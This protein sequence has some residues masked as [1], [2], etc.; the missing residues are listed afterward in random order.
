MNV[1]LT[2]RILEPSNPK[3]Q[4]LVLFG[5]LLVGH[6]AVAIPEKA[7][8]FAV[9]L[10]PGYTRA[11]LFSTAIAFIVTQYIYQMCRIAHKKYPMFL[12][13]RKHL[14]F[15]I[16]LSVAVPLILAPA[17]AGGYFYF[18][19]PYKNIFKNT[20]YFFQI[21]PIVVLFVVLGNFIFELF[22]WVQDRY[23]HDSANDPI[24]IDARGRVIKSATAMVLVKD[25]DY[26]APPS[27]IEPDCELL[28]FNTIIVTPKGVRGAYGMR[29]SEY[30]AEKLI[31][32]E[33]RLPKEFFRISE[34]VFVNIPKVHSITADRLERTY[35]FFLDTDTNELKV[36]RRRA[37]DFRIIC[38]ELG[39][40][41][42]GEKVPYRD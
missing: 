30:L 32:I 7:S 23:A 39:I 25:S 5:S 17:L 8:F 13:P 42:K 35:Y 27:E 14:W 41:K 1:T 19:T 36:A 9:I 21:Y 37:K 4:I 2:E 29:Q 12:N 3:A 40:L 31:H 20:V 28:R 33:A 11:L 6:A 22:F 15:R 24:D 26:V 10:I 18:F 34:Y 16:G 38:E